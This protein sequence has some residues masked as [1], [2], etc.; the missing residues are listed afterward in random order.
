MR[1]A[2]TLL[3]ARLALADDSCK[4][5]APIPNRSHA[6][7]YPDPRDRCVFDSSD[8]GAC[9][10]EPDARPPQWPAVARGPSDPKPPTHAC[11]RADA[12]TIA[13]LRT[14]PAPLL[15]HAD[16]RTSCEYAAPRLLSRALSRP[17]TRIIRS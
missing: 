4:R 9:S 1:L 10:D 3:A 14:A 7:F 6:F 17:P 13:A 15:R 11:S 12:A 16:A 2:A 5:W 8:A